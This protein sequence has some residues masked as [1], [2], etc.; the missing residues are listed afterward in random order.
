MSSPAPAIDPNFLL[1]ESGIPRYDLQEGFDLPPF[2]P[3][4]FPSAFRT[5]I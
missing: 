5:N 4:L 1:T 3:P 2:P